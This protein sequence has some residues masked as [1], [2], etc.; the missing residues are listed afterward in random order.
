MSSEDF[1]KGMEA[2]AK[3]FEEKFRL[4]NE[5]IDRV[6]KNINSRLDGI[7]SINDV[8]IDDLTSMEKKRLYDLNTVVDINELDSTEKEFLIALIY[9][10]ANMSDSTT[11]LQ[12]CFVRSI[13]NHLG[14]ISPQVEVDLHSIES[15]KSINSQKAILQ[16]L[17]EF[18]FLEDATHK[19]LK[20]YEYILSYFSVN[21]RG[22]T[23]IREKIDAIYNA[24]GLEGIAEHYGYTPDEYEDLNF[25]SSETEEQIT[26]M[27]ISRI[28]YI[29][30]GDKRIIKNSIVNINTFIMCEGELVFDN[31]TIYYNI[32][33]FTNEITLKQGA[34]L[35]ILNSKVICKGRDEDFFIKGEGDNNVVLK[36]CEFYDCSYFLEIIR[37]SNTEFVMDSCNI[38]NPGTYFLN[39]RVEKGLMTNCYIKAT[40]NIRNNYTDSIFYAETYGEHEFTIGE[41]VVYGDDLP[42]EIT[43]NKTWENSFSYSDTIFGIFN[44]SYKNCSFINVIN[45]ISNAGKISNSEFLN[46]KEVIDLGTYKSNNKIISCI[47]K[48]CENVIKTSDRAYISNCQ[49]EKCRGTIMNISDSATVEFC[50]FYNIVNTKPVYV[51][52]ES[53]FKFSR[54]K[55]SSCS[56]VKKCIFDGV[57]L[58]DEFLI[59]GNVY[60]KLSGPV[61]YIE[62]STFR[63]CKTNRE[64]GKIIKEYD[65]YYGLFNRKVEVKAILIR[66][67]T[68]LDKVNKEND[69]TD[70]VIIRGKT[71]L[72]IKIGATVIAAGLGGVTSAIITNTIVDKLIKDTDMHAE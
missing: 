66:N 64:S 56:T 9:T 42:L 8:I 63:N 32:Q 48:E 55:N 19:Y 22:V 6:S 70:D 39:I 18:L 4:Q 13:K 31:C 62:D 34:T 14:I 71:S 10:V 28:L 25:K 12:K 49:F 54:R 60:E 21:T 43:E 11:E 52:Q 72:G 1:N 27:D 59:S 16:T 17:M 40:T 53:S 24:T 20:E 29:K 57:Y 5:A 33:D 58:I 23:E 30:Q 45:S 69:Y 51:N 44:G 38:V 36:N 15:I 50:E 67:C 37:G 41:C 3:P 61:A 68:G 47:F 2:G 65:H 35:E 7:D 46:C 26:E